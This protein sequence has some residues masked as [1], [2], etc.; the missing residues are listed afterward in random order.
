MNEELW[1][2]LFKDLKGL[3]DEEF[4]KILNKLD[5]SPDIPFC[6]VDNTPSDDK[7]VAK[8]IDKLAH[9]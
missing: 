3:S 6:I 5:K 8:E 4:A 1:E 7:V 2:E 9:A